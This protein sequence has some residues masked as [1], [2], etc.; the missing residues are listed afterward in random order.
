LR[1]IKIAAAVATKN[2]LLKYVSLEFAFAMS[3]CQG[4]SS[5]LNTKTPFATIENNNKIIIIFLFFNSK[6]LLNF[7]A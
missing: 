2:I 5:S 4:S 3:I 1:L 7:D 6:N